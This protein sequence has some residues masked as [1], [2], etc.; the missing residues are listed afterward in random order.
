MIFYPKETMSTLKNLVSK[1]NQI[2]NDEH[3]IVGVNRYIDAIK[4]FDNTIAEVAVIFNPATVAKMKNDKPPQLYKLK[5]DDIF[6]SKKEVQ[7]EVIECDLESLKTEKLIAFMD[8]RKMIF[9]QLYIGTSVYDKLEQKS[10]KTVVFWETAY[11]T[12]EQGNSTFTVHNYK[13]VNL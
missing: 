11:T 2:R 9:D 8:D 7:G 10:Q 13:V 1:A 4:E 5:I 6:V 3:F 12:H